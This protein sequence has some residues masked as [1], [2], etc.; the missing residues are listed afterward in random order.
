M[1][2]KKNSLDY[3]AFTISRAKLCK[4]R[5]VRK[6]LFHLK[7]PNHWLIQD[8][9]HLSKLFVTH[10]K[11]GQFYEQYMDFVYNKSRD[12]HNGLLELL[13]SILTRVDIENPRFKE[14]LNYRYYFGPKLEF[15]LEKFFSNGDERLRVKIDSYVWRWI[16]DRII[17]EKF[18]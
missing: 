16:E 17:A 11:C 13:D 18:S 14:F 9:T 5:K 8:I 1:K 2:K 12:Y 6:K 10:N 7:S 15:I 3:Y 4:T